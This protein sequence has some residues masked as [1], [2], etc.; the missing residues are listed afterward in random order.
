MPCR[1]PGIALIL[2]AFS[3]EKIGIPWKSCRGVIMRLK[4][5]GAT[6]GCWI[7]TLYGET[8]GGALKRK[9]ALIGAVRRPHPIIRSGYWLDS[10]RIF[11]PSILSYPSQANIPEELTPLRH[12][13]SFIC[14]DAGN[15]LKIPYFGWILT[16][17]GRVFPVNRG[18]R[19]FQRASAWFSAPA[20]PSPNIRTRLNIVL[21][22]DT[23]HCASRSPTCQHVVAHIIFFHPADDDREE[24]EDRQKKRWA[25]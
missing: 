17:L 23:Y 3:G 7:W 20:V 14:T 13:H 15:R 22:D 6:L 18:P 19:R 16:T 10:P 5:L 1:E 21:Y 11:R 9:I 4:Y 12:S 8:F 24:E 25:I 2:S